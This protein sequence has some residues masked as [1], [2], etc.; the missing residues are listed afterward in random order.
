VGLEARRGSLEMITRGFAFALATE[1]FQKGE[2]IAQKLAG[3]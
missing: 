3:R 2:E 1:I